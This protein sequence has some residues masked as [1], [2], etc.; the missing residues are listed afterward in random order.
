MYFVRST[1]EQPLKGH[2]EKSGSMHV[3]LSKVG[4]L[5]SSVALPLLRWRKRQQLT[6]RQIRRNGVSECLESDLPSVSISDN[7]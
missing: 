2:L 6:H 3:T 7:C 4:T 5:V 1:T